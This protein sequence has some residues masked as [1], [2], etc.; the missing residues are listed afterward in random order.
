MEEVLRRNSVMM[1]E[2]SKIIGLTFQPRPT[3]VFIVTYPKCGTTWVSFI[4][5]TLRSRG[6]LDFDEIV[7]VCPWTVFAHELNID[8]NSDQVGNGTR[9]FK[10]HENYDLIPKGAK[11]IY[12][13]RNPHDVCV[14][15]YHFLI[16]FVGM[17]GTDIPI[18]DF[19][20]Q[21]FLGAGSLSGKI[22]HHYLSFYEHIQDDNVLFVFYEDLI[23]NL[24]VVIEQIANFMNIELDD[25]LRKITLEHSS[26]D[27]MKA[28]S[29]Q[30]DEHIVFDKCKGR[31]GL[32]EDFQNRAQ[33]V[34]KGKQGAGNIEM[35]PEHHARL[36]ETWRNVFGTAT[37][38]N[39]YSE[40]WEKYSPLSP[41]N[42][43]NVS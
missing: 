30:F 22:W 6:H 15:F 2:E 11:Y 9:I 8:L 29:T 18:D 4:A 33:K 34:N 25:E 20:D 19:I 12:V 32:A 41:L 37:G 14:S 13:V 1:D 24:E 17:E 43:S 28:R 10:S 39:S 35:T 42:I 21:L 27:F 36:D 38:L 31:M 3:D 5:H 7:Q 26:F 23:S 16:K 40:L